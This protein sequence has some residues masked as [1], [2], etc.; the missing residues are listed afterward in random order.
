M[1]AI[2]TDSYCGE[3]PIMEYQLKLD[4]PLRLKVT[5]HDEKY[6]AVVDVYEAWRFLGDAANS[7]NEETR[8]GKVKTWLAQKLNVDLSEIAESTARLFHE[9]VYAIG[10]KAQDDLKKTAQSIVCS[11]PSTLESPAIIPNGM[12]GLSELGSTTLGTQS[13]K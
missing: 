4:R 8:W 3:P 10:G 2:D 6:V 1:P 9:T 5:T 13:L 11:L 12:S 7:P